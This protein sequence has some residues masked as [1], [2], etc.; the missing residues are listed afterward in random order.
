MY[1]QPHAFHQYFWTELDESMLEPDLEKTKEQG[2]NT[3]VLQVDWGAFMPK[4]DVEAQTFTWAA[5][6][7]AKLRRM[8]ELADERGMYVILWFTWARA[9]EGIGAKR[10]EASP[11]LGGTEH[12]PFHGYLVRDYPA[13]AINDAFAWRAC[14]TFHERIAKVT[15]LFENV[16]LDPLD[17][18]HLN[19]NYWSWADAENLAAW[20]AHLR[21]IDPDLQHWNERWGEEN[22]T[23]G[24]VLLPVDSHV[25][26]T[27]AKPAGG[28][29]AGLAITPYDAPKWH[30]FNDW[31]DAVFVRIAREILAALERG[32]PRAPIGQRIDRWR[33]GQWRPRTW[34]PWRPPDETA[35]APSRFF[36]LTYYPRTR[37]DAEKS[38][39]RLAETIRNVRERD[40]RG[41]PIMLW[42]TG[43]DLAGLFGG[44]DAKAREEAQ[45]GYL[46]VV[47]AT[48][49]RLGLIG[50][51]WWVW[52]D[53]HMSEASL[54][55]GIVGTDGAE[56]KA[57][58]LLR[59]GYGPKAE[60]E[61]G[62]GRPRGE[63][64]RPG[65]PRR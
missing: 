11:D 45:Y 19:M 38:E 28:P 53:Y 17:W 29:Y 57:V 40:E 44:D 30:D 42:E 23:W 46:D 12:P 48:A 35:L 7:E 1:Y 15:S 26:N 13:I 27:A 64:K 63:K 50:F 39:E 49:E 5:D 9:P 55:Y 4:V 58:E 51:G 20:R 34:A 31:H 52:R 6:S 10:Y 16:I 43:I 21:G 59:W 47:A 22:A 8:L 37:E 24:D 14:L 32:D 36:F 3:I 60:A 25:Q 61:E 62:T 41:Y 56:K 65:R 33:Y 18:Q 54:Q 2:L